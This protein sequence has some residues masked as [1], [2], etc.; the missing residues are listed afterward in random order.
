MLSSEKGADIEATNIETLDFSELYRASAQLVVASPDASLL[1]TGVEHRVVVRDAETLSITQVFALAKGS[2]DALLFSC[3]SCF[4]AAASRASATLCVW[5][6]VDEWSCAIAEGV[7][8]I[9]HVKFAPDGR[10]LLVF[11]D[12]QLRITVWSLVTKDAAYIQF[13]KFKDKGYCFRKDGRYFALAERKECKD[14]VSIYDCED[15]T[16]LKHFPVDTSDLEDIAWS[17]DGRFIAV[18][19]C[20]LEYKM[21]IYSPDGRLITSYSAYEPGLGIKSAAWSPS[22]QFLAIGSYDD[23]C[24]LIHNMTWKPLIDLAHPA[25]LPFPDIPVYKESNMRDIKDV[26]R[27]K[28]WSMSGDNRPRIH[29]ELHRPP[30]TIPTVRPDADK[31]GPPRRGI[32]FASFNCTGSLLCTRSDAAP[33]AL[34]IWD[35]TRLAQAALLLQMQAVR[36]VAWNPMRPGVLAVSCGGA[37]IYLWE[38]GTGACAIEVPAV[39]FSIVGMQWSPD[40]RSLVLMDRDKFTVAFLVEKM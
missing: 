8:G 31:P 12:F 36:C 14:T 25:Q 10:H 18:W 6:L 11:S 15:W 19:E 20:L 17:P 3:D 29:Y 16:L 24:R 35:L 2:V 1:A 38:A 40:G 9:A 5:S 4:V 13:P 27:M 34:W 22:S 28:I 39:G 37:C 7:A 23:K 21:L 33:T 30:V 26:S 32:G